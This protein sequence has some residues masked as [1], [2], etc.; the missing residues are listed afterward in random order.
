M[1][2]EEI[3]SFLGDGGV[4]VVSF[5]RD[6]EPYSIPVSYGYDPAAG[7]FYVRL[8]FAPDSEKEAFAGPNRRVSIVVHRETDDGWASVVARGTLRE[9]TEAAIDA[10]VVR[11]I[12]RVDIPLVSI[13][14]APTR[15]LDFRLY[16]VAVDDLSG[17]TERTERE[18][19]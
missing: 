6:D 14:D 17:R 11:A 10:Q 3:E 1:T 12:R 4:A 5:A 13:F 7:Q 16:R 18:T 9:V 19:E 15:E 8:G 2:D